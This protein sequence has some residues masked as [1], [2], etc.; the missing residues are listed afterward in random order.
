MKT[1]K[2]FILRKLYDQNYIVPVGQNIVY[3]KKSLRINETGVFI[4]NLLQKDYSL[5]Q[6]IQE[7]LRSYQPDA[8]DQASIKED[9]NSFLQQLKNYGIIEMEMPD[10]VIQENDYCYFSFGDLF[11]EFIGESA[12]LCDAMID[13]SCE[14]RD[15]LQTQSWQLHTSDSIPCLSGTLL[16]KSR[17]IDI[18]QDQEAYIL[19]F[20]QNTFLR[21]CRLSLDGKKADFYYRGGCIQQGKMELFFGM[22][23]VLFYAMQ[24]KG[25][26]ALHSASILYRDKAW[27]F[28][29]VSGTGKSTH[30]NLWHTLLGVTRLNGDLN[31]IYEKEGSFYVCPTPWCGTSEIYTTNIYPLGGIV[32][33]K[34]DATNHVINVAL[35]E[36]QLLVSQR[37][38]SPAWTIDQLD[39]NLNFSKE[40]TDHVMIC[41]LC[42]N[43]ETASVQ[44][45]KAYIDQYLD[46]GIKDER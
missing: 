22:K 9:V 39:C 1:S 12:Y 16:I 45:M 35:D 32:L 18:Y 29:A 28:S 15:T 14:N 33:L 6:I 30:T 25:Y 8:K 5:E 44:V 13:F 31:V 41:R 7:V 38:V 4:W 2:E 11:V 23:T 34:Q 17:E 42:C 21:L 36:K 26:F 40:L 43:M 20:P 10:K 27:L 3:Y 19:L 46:M 24:Q 37:M